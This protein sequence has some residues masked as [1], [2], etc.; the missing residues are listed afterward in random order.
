MRQGDWS[1]GAWI[2]RG[3]DRSG[4]G[5]RAFWRI[6]GR[7]T[8]GRSCR[9]LCGFEGNID[10]LFW[11]LLGRFLVEHVGVSEGDVRRDGPA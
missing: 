6:V 8:L 11:D 9:L 2:V 10:S 4:D 7:F 3:R 5:R 1:G